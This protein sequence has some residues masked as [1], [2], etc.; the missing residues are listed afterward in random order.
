[1]S[2]KYYTI[3]FS[4]N[5]EGTDSDYIASA[6]IEAEQVAPGKYMLLDEHTSKVTPYFLRLEYKSTIMAK[7][8]EDGCL[9]F[10]GVTRDKSMNKLKL[11]NPGSLFLYILLGISTILFSFSTIINLATYFIYD[12]VSNV[13]FGYIHFLVL[14]I[15]IITFYL[16][17]HNKK[18]SKKESEKVIERHTPKWLR[19]TQ[20]V[21]FIFVLVNFVT[22]LALLGA[23]CD[24]YPKDKYLING[25]GKSLK[26]VT[27]TEKYIL[28]DSNIRTRIFSGGWMFFSLYAVCSLT[29]LLEIRRRKLYGELLMAATEKTE[30]EK[31]YPLCQCDFPV[32]EQ[33]N[34]PPSHMDAD[35]ETLRCEKIL[36]EA[37]NGHLTNLDDCGIIPVR[38]PK[39]QGLLISLLGL[40]GYI[41][42]VGIIIS[43]QPGSILG[44]FPI[45]AYSGI[46]LIIR[47][48]K[49][50]KLKKDELIETAGGCLT[51]IPNFFLSVY[52]VRQVLEAIYIIIKSDF[53][54]AVTGQVSF[55]FISSGNYKLSTGEPVA[56]LFTGISYVI[57]LPLIILMLAGLTEFAN[58]ASRT[59]QNKILKYF[60]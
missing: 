41:L 18:R 13:Y 39:D 5:A 28:H 1:M 35:A 7:T 19:L 23:K 52:I 2:S 38:K 49:T 30:K 29:G 40:A 8:L 3:I 59:I 9:K 45:V 15:C 22:G 32:N 26:E 6:Y 48:I 36:E 12:P 47:L 27:K 54:L 24:I 42:A 53:I 57:T 56:P 16:S 34:P 60:N 33:T 25:N 20:N 11:S 55:V 4:K 21:F 51:I 44:L 17:T 43:A 10:V 58:T 50:G 14:I 31:S 37:K 46:R